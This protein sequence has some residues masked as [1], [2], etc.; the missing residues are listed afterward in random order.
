[1][2][3]QMRSLPA[4]VTRRFVDL[5]IGQVHCYEAGRRVAGTP[6]LV[7]LHASPWSARTLAPLLVRLGKQRYVIA[8]DT[9]GQGDSCAPD[10]ESVDIPYL[11]DAT[12][13]LL[14]ALDI[15]LCDLF[16]S[17][18]GG[19]TA[20]EMAIRHPDRVRRLIVEGLGVPPQALK[21]EYSAQIRKTPG[22]D[23]YGTQFLWAFQTIK[24]M[25]SFF[26]YYRRDREHRRSRDMPSPDELHVLT[27]D[28]LKNLETYHHAYIAAWQNNPGGERFS[29]IP[30]PTL[31]TRTTDDGAEG[32]MA[33]LA[34]VIP[35]CIVR[36]LPEGA[37]PGDDVA[38]APLIEDFLDADPVPA[39]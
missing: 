33:A 22:K 7:L 38:L 15:G 13:K 10:T 27:L 9:L 29:M 21:D 1:M 24:D 8:P 28:L 16:G 18:T 34:A 30:V 36:P 39:T 25:F 19:H 6:P 12:V 4:G 26:P 2:E 11:A 5:D 23:H 35:T 14:D 17:H 37:A 31:L 20:T 3:P 32:A